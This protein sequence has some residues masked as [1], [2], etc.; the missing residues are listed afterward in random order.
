M[1]TEQIKVIAEAAHEANRVYCRSLG[2]YSQKPWGRAAQSQRDSLVAGVL[3]VINNPGTTP[4][5]SHE[6]WLA[7]KVRTGW[8]YGPV[9]DHRKK[10]H[11]CFR[12]YA[13]LPPEQR[14]KDALF[15]GVVRALL[16]AYA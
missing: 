15:L 8:S 14:V 12:P 1:T 2:D 4:E 16:S 5:K 11:P 7:E 3:N 10:T 13:E 6:S 9:K